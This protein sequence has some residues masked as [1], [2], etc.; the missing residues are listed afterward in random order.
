M[1]K[2]LIAGIATAALCSAPAM[3]A[4]PAGIFNWS[5]FYIGGNGGYGFGSDRISHSNDFFAIST[6]AI[7]NTKG[8]LGG[9]QLDSSASRARWCLAS[10]PH[11]TPAA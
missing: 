3:A 4:P 7:N 5:G 8:S 6:T 2:S 9:G 1:K 10:R 11:S